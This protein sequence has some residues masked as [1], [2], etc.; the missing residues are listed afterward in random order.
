M[1]IL[2][3]T[4]KL[5][6]GGVILKLLLPSLALAGGHPETIIDSPEKI[7]GVL[8]TVAA[9]LFTIL[10]ALAVVMI[11]YAAFLYL[12]AAGS[13]DRLTSAK[14]TLIYAIVAIV[15][16]LVAGGIPVL[17]LNLLSDGGGLGLPP[18][19]CPPFPC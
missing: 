11:V 16:A 15:V 3:K 14:K 12:T 9:W 18:G 1:N 8:G 7:V 2:T 5:I 19:G 4:K 10:M 17:I 6:G 13:P